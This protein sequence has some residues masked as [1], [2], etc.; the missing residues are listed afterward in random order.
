M[1][2]CLPPMRTTH[3][4]PAPAGQWC[5][6][7]WGANGR[8]VVLLPAVLFDRTGWWPTAADLRPHATVI[9]VDLPGHGTS[10]RRD[11]YDPAE[12]VDDLA[13]L[14]DSLQLRRAPVIV[15]HGPSAL[16]ADLFAARYA[17]HAVIAVD[18]SPAADLSVGVDSYLRT[19]DLEA[20]PEQYHDLVRVTRDAGLLAAYANG[21]QTSPVPPASGVTPTRLAVHSQPSPPCLPGDA[22]QW[23]HEIYDVPGRFAHLTAGRRLITDLRALL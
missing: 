12:L 19:W 5:Y 18:P 10:A 1:T 15:G 14:V 2:E 6:D 21:L 22:G 7:L 17:T 13:C 23:R 3:H 9:A 16:L 20:V 4:F 8:P 11:S